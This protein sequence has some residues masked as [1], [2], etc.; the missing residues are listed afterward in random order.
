MTKEIYNYLVM[1]ILDMQK[2]KLSMI[3]KYA[4]DYDK[5]TAALDLLN[6]Y[7]KGIEHYLNNTS[8]MEGEHEAPFVIIGSTVVVRE[9]SSGKVHSFTI[10][11]PSRSHSPN[12]DSKPVSC[13]C[14]FGSSLL[15]KKE[16][17]QVSVERPGG[18]AAGVIQGITY[19]L[20]L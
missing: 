11:P 15:L 16:G 17:H 12:S 8:I 10:V 20:K 13:F 19:D 2:N 7:I 5:Y 9:K 4:M 6:G 14:G 18:M 1:H 3:S